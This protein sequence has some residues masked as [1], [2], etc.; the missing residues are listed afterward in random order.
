MPPKRR[1]VETVWHIQLLLVIII[2]TGWVKNIIK[3]SD[4]DFEPSYK[5][6]VIHLV[7][8]IPPVGMITGWMDHGK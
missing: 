7:G 4:C 8:L 5:A 1:T 6:E 3:L 2:G